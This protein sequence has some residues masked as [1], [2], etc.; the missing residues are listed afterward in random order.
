MSIL[1]TNAIQTTAGKTILQSTGSILQVVQITKSDTIATGNLTSTGTP[2]TTNTFNILSGSITPTS[3]SSKILCIGS[4]FYSAAGQT[5]SIVLFRSGTPISIGDA[6]GNRRRAT[7]GTG[8]Q[9][10]ANQIS[11][12]GHIHFLDTPATTSALTYSVGMWGDNGNTVCINR[13]INDTDNTTGV[14]TASNLIL[15]EV[16]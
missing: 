11:G 4:I 6:A 13:S 12:H 10:D 9:V 3:N 16:A 2:S 14:R 1:R 5:P 7:A 8:L 15:L